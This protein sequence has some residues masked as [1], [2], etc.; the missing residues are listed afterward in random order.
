MMLRIKQF[1]E[2]H[3]QPASSGDDTEQRLKL[4]TTALLIEMMRADLNVSDQEKNQLR[5]ILGTHFKFEETEIDRILEQAGQENHAAT[6]Y[7]QFTSLI[8]EHYSQEQKVQLVEQLWQ[9]A[10]ADSHVDKFEEHLVRTLAD[11][12]HVPHRSFIQSKHRVLGNNQ[13]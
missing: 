10:Y 4:A 2:Q 5:K 9:L 11:L 6:D 13:P 3:L 12:L 1:F 7:Y 8:N